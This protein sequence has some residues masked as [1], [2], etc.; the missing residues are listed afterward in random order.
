M[1]CNGVYGK[2]NVELR[3]KRPGFT[4]NSDITSTFDFKQVT[5]L[6]VCEFTHSKMGLIASSRVMGELN[7][8]PFI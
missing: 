8:M 2:N 1:I 3:I 6:S 4:P 5:S 7:K